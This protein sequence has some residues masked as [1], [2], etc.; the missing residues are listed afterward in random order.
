MTENSAILLGRVEE[1]RS[2]PKD[3]SEKGPGTWMHALS[4]PSPPL[5]TVTGAGTS[6]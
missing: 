3:G 4:L 5:T 6:L 2:H 1:D